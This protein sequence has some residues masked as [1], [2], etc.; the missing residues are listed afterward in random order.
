MN[1]FPPPQH[2]D[3]SDA[4]EM[5]LKVEAVSQGT[6]HTIRLAQAANDYVAARRR[7]EAAEP[8]DWERMLVNVDYAWHRL[9]EEVD[10]G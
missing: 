6:A 4:A 10:R 7:N 2:V 3:L 9:C 5:R 1:Q 8:C